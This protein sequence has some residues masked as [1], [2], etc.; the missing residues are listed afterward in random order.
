MV[1]QIKRGSLILLLVCIGSISAQDKLYPNEFPL[2]DVTLLDGPF[3]RA[4]YLNVSHLLKY[5]TDRLLY[6]YRKEAGLPTGNA[7]NYSN[8]AGLDGHVGGH[9]LS[10]LSMQYAATG[11]MQCKERLDYMITELKKCQD[12]NGKDADFVGYV[13][14][15]PDG[16]K[17]WRT[18]KSGNTSIVNDYWVPWYNIHKTYQGLRDAWMYGENSDAQLMFFKLCDWGI[19]IC[20]G[21]SDAQMQSMLGNEHGGINEMYADAYNMSNRTSKYINFAKKFSHRE[22]L[23]PMSQGRD[24][25]DGKH[26]N[27]QVPKVVGF[28]RIAEESGDTTY[29]K[30]AE[31]FWN[32]VTTRR[33]LAV[34][35]NSNNERFPAA[36][37]CMEYITGREGIESCNTHN[38]LKLTEGLFRMK[39]EVKYV[40]FF[41]KALFNHILSTQHPIHGGYVYFTPSHP[42]HYRVYSTPDVCM[43]CC[44]GT[45]ME[46]HT[47]YG[48]FIYTH[49]GDS[50]FVNLSIASELDWKEKGVKIRQETNFPDE[51]QMVLKINTDAPAQFKLLIRHPKWV[52]K[53]A[54][55]IVVGSDTL[56][57]QSEPS[58]YVELDRTWK[59]GDVVTIH[60]K[61]GFSYEELINI[62]SWIAL[63]KGPIVLAAKTGTNG[64]SGLLANADRWAHSPGGSLMDVNTA[65]KLKID[66]GTFQTAFTPVEN[67]P[68]TFK[69]PGIFASSADKNLELVPFF[70]VHDTRYMMYWN[71]E[72]TGE[73]PVS[74][75]PVPLNLKRTSHTMRLSHGALRFSFK[76]A[77]PSRLVNVYTLAGKKIASISAQNKMMNLDYHKE[78]IRLNKGMYVVQIISQGICSSEKICISR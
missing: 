10:A 36:S 15:I 3:K 28:Q 52:R 30:A 18:I 65:S 25:L 19:N 23:D 76:N 42:R 56:K 2:G 39:P 58:S 72:V 74:N 70:R 1:K 32:T 47:K 41:E 45:G 7:Q 38:M 31:F 64:V 9:Y 69:A 6:C 46:N 50:L 17:M 59:D 68:M 67:N 14:G 78:E 12:A 24:N 37:K 62:P 51:E 16:K 33:S 26:A 20:S 44:V 11:N 40:D 49:T 5:T 8:W 4:M 13:S 71:A 55:N 66:R 60:M 29:Y 27:T 63:K 73:P 21:L 34:G 54:M 61:M 48:Q 35:G 53:G 75:H 77:D 22:I 43:W 57:K